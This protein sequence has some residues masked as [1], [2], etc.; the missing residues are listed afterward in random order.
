M[1]LIVCSHFVKK[2]EETDYFCVECARGITMDLTDAKVALIFMKKVCQKI[3]SK[4]HYSN[5]FKMEAGDKNCNISIKGFL[6][7]D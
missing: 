1:M 4:I 7:I 5:S 3:D 2:K 6:C